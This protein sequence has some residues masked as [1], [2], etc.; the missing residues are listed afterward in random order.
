MFVCVSV[1]TLF[2]S[3]SFSFDLRCV[4]PVY[5]GATR[6]AMKR[7]LSAR[8]LPQAKSVITFP[9]CHHSIAIHHYLELFGNAQPSDGDRHC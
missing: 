1:I 5:L 2:L 9:G 4:S 7:G 3:V 6:T 8:F